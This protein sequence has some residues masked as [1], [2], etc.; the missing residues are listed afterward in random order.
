M[1]N[2]SIHRAPKLAREPEPE[3]HHG[4]EGESANDDETGEHRHET[5]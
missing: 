2:L 3:P 5:G 1:K 4:G